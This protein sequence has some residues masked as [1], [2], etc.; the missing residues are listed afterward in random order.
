MM[1]LVSS[2]EGS[3]EM[4]MQFKGCLNTVL[5]SYLVYLQ[6]WFKR[7][8]ALYVESAESAI[9]SIQLVSNYTQ[10]LHNGLSS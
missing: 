4:P 2:I 7:F 3:L 5:I 8:I 6:T 1:E 10:C 9:A